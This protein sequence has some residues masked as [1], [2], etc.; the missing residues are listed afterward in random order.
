[1]MDAIQVM[2]P[3]AAFYRG[4]ACL[5][6]PEGIVGIGRKEMDDDGT[7]PIDGSVPAVPTNS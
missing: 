4:R 6:E 1:M 2:G 7:W 5:N 3:C